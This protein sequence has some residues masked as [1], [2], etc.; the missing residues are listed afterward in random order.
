MSDMPLPEPTERDE[1]LAL[2]LIGTKDETRLRG[3][4]RGQQRCGTCHFYADPDTA[5]S[6]CWHDT[7]EIMVGSSWWCDRWAQVG[8]PDEQASPEALRTGARLHVDKVEAMQW[9]D[10]PRSDEQCNTCRY[11]LNPAES[12]SYCWHPGLQ[13]GVGFDHWCQGWAQIPGAV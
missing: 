5:I 11:Y 9:R 2:E 13:T 10:H 12:V 1:E 7:L 8:G 3:T 4:P 6:Y